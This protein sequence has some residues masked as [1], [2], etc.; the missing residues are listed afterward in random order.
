MCD[1]NTFDYRLKSFWVGRFIVFY[2]KVWKK[3]EEK[4]KERKEGGGRGKK[5]RER[6]SASVPLFSSQSKQHYSKDRHH[7]TQSGVM[8]YPAGPSVRGKDLFF[9]L[10]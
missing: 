6:E 1:Q 3:K 7:D 9:W 4:R 2:E 5:E 10:C 8:L